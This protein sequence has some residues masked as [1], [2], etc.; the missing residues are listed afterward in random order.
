M[1]KPSLM[2]LTLVILPL[3]LCNDL[4]A[5]GLT[6]ANIT[7][8]H[9]SVKSMNMTSEASIPGGIV[10]QLQC[11][12]CDCCLGSSDPK[13]TAQTCCYKSTCGDPRKPPN[14][15]ISHRISCG[16]DANCK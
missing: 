12:F 8:K 2:F 4:H 6:E 10:V 13:C 14:T 11:D 15:C 7:E 9:F 1:A 16:C 3:L 5:T